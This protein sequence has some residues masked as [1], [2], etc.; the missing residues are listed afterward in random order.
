[1]SDNEVPLIRE[2]KTWSVY[3]HIFPNGKKYVGITSR[4]P[5]ERWEANGNG[6]RGQSFLWNAITK[7]GWN[8]IK[9]EIL[10]TCLS[11]EEAYKKEIELIDKLNLTNP[12]YGYNIAEGGKD[13]C[14]RKI[15]CLTTLEKFSSM[16]AVCDKYGI[17]IRTFRRYLKKYRGD[18]YHYC[19]K[20]GQTR[21][22][23]DYYEKNK[24]Y[25]K[26]TYIGPTTQIIN[27][28]PLE[29]FEDAKEAAKAYNCRVENIR[30]HLKGKS[31]HCCLDENG[32]G[33]LWE[34]YDKDKTYSR[35][36]FPKEE[37]RKLYMHHYTPVI[38]LNTLKVYPTIIDASKELHIEK[39]SISSA[40]A[41]KRISAGKDENGNRLI[42]QYYDTNKHYD[43]LDVDKNNLI[44]IQK[45]RKHKTIQC[46]ETGAIYLSAKQACKEFNVSESLIRTACLHSNRTAKAFHF[47]YVDN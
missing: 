36:I 30:N 22:I 25:N 4:T 32:D 7:Y 40:C 5:E 21:L 9:H 24:P 19:G 29:V 1:M 46:V 34:K 44:Y 26:I 33:I 39:S 37:I 16:A 3:V 18:P 6:Y 13:S 17:A 45:D 11:E 27:L 23:W 15:I 20:F 38:C 10:E 14:Q 31:T 41:G 12:I 47:K 2:K 35:K 8:N 42:W 28:S 43:K